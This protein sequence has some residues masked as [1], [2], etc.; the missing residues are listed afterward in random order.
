MP[1][2]EA[3]DNQPEATATPRPTWDCSPNTLPAFFEAVIKWLPKRNPNYRNAVE[4]GVTVDGRKTLFH[5]VN[6][7]NRYVNNEIKN[8]AG[9]KGTFRA[10]VLIE[11][12]QL[13]TITSRPSMYLT[14]PN[15][16]GE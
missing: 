15:I 5:S 9:D 14:T 7:I 10:P 3:S 13:V 8:K 2:A 12:S 16:M 1:S 6:H 4:Q 11:A